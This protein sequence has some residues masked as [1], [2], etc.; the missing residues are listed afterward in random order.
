MN[1]SGDEIILT[2]AEF[3]SIKNIIKSLAPTVEAVL[4]AD[5]ASIS[6][7]EPG[8]YTALI[9]LQEAWESDEVQNSLD[10]WD[11]DIND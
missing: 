8:L 9:D 5:I 10:T 2:H 4:N 3:E 6:Q 11:E 7:E 1:K